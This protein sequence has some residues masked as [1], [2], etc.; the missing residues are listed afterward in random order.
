M[1]KHRFFAIFSLLLCLVTEVT[2]IISWVKNLT[3]SSGKIY[4]TN[5]NSSSTTLWILK[6]G[7]TKLTPCY[8]DF[9]NQNCTELPLP[10][11]LDYTK[12]TSIK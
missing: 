5:S 9:W 10:N 3:L 4:Y 1:L 2:S 12:I 8:L 7:E 11:S 6:N